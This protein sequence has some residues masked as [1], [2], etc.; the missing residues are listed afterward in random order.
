[1][2]TIWFHK[3]KNKAETSKTKWVKM[4]PQSNWSFL[5]RSVFVFSALLSVFV[6]L[7]PFFFSMVFVFAS[8]AFLEFFFHEFLQLIFTFLGTWKKMQKTMK[9]AR[10]HKKQRKKIRRKERNKR[11]QKNEQKATQKRTLCFLWLFPSRFIRFLNPSF[12]CPVERILNLEAMK[13]CI[14]GRSAMG[15]IAIDQWTKWTLPCATPCHAREIRSICEN[16]GSVACNPSIV[17]SWAGQIS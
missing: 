13:S 8:F 3:K 6:R 16:S 2:E 9:Q 15:M 5:F 12:T 4:R 10:A 11:K 1:M 7:F 17:G 14:S